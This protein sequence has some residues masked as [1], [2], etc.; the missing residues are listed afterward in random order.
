[1]IN[2][3]I[4]RRWYMWSLREERKEC[5]SLGIW[6]R[7][8]GV[9]SRE[10][11]SQIVCNR[12]TPSCVTS[13]KIF[14]TSLV[15]NI[16]KHCAYHIYSRSSHPCFYINCVFILSCY[17]FLSYNTALLQLRWPGFAPWI[18]KISWRRERLPTPVFWPGE[19]HGLYSHGV[20]KS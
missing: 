8:F 2:W 15:W 4:I 18:G 20:A 10:H 19:F 6:D 12:R 16:C 11:E 5:L 9:G 13:K 3:D 1:M 7:R 17:S 14:L